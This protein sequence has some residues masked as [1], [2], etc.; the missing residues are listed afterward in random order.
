MDAT[1][2]QQFQ[3]ERI[4]GADNVIKGLEIIIQDTIDYVSQRMVSGNR[5]RQSGRSL[6]IGRAN[7]I[8][9]TSERWSHRCT[10]IHME[11]KNGRYSKAQMSARS[12]ACAAESLDESPVKSPMPACNIGVEWASWG[13]KCGTVISR[14]PPHLHRWWSR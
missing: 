2:M 12:P 8:E 4:W 13:I 11:S 7:C 3:E 10:E 6:S 5:S 9:E 1:Q 14:Q